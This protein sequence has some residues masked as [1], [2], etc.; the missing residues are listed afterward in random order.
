[1]KKG[2]MFHGQLKLNNRSLKMAV[3]NA[4]RKFR[5][6]VIVLNCNTVF[7]SLMLKFRHNAEF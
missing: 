6:G 4:K 2:T 3:V 7:L 5:I 1:M